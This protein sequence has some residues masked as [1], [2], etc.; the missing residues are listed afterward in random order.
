MP[1]NLHPH[2]Q[3]VSGK[4]TGFENKGFVG[5]TDS[6]CWKAPNSSD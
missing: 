4:V 1:S 3:G 5:M 6:R 2:P